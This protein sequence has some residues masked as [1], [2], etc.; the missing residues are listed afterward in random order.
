[1]TIGNILDRCD[2]ISKLLSLLLIKS[3]EFL[4]CINI[5]IT[6]HLFPSVLI[7]IRGHILTTLRA[8]L[9]IR[10]FII[11][12]VLLHFQSVRNVVTFEELGIIGHVATGIFSISSFS[13]KLFDFGCFTY[14]EIAFPRILNHLITLL[15]L[16]FN[17]VAFTLLHFNR[18]FDQLLTIWS[19][20]HFYIP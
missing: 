19:L 17:H 2:T 6:R 20:R 14:V 12:L 9:E 1:M 15:D 8:E 11:H 10:L 16:S 13:V 5:L 18:L 3:F 4:I 7:L